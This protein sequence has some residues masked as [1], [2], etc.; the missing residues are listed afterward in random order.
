LRQTFGTGRELSQQIAA[1]ESNRKSNL[2]D[3][4]NPNSFQEPEMNRE[5]PQAT[6][7]SFL[8]LLRIVG[9]LLLGAAAVAGLPKGQRPA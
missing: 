5:A 3:A 1:L 7:I 8:V 4:R 2:A 6:T 9:L